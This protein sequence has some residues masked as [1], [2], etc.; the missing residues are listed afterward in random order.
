MALVP[1]LWVSASFA[2]TSDDLEAARAHLTEARDSAN[3]AVAAFSAAENK[4]AETEQHIAALEASID[5]LKAKAAQLQSIVRQR[6]VYAYTHKGQD[7]DIVVDAGNP[8]EAARRSQLL[9]QANERDNTAVRKLAA[10]NE[11][12][13]SQQDTLRAQESQQQA[14]KSQLEAK[15]ADL[16]GKLADAQ[17]AASALQAKLDAEIA[18]AKAAEDAAKSQALAAE[19]ASIAASQTVS[20]TGPGQVIGTPIGGFQCPVSGAA[21][22]DDFGGARGHPGIDMFVPTG[23]PAVAV[24]SGSVRY[25]ANEGDGGN[26]AYLS[27]S[28]G[29]TYFYAHFSSFVGGARDV[30]QGEIIGLTGMTGNASAP[31]LHFEIRLGGPNGSR[32]NPYPTLKGAGC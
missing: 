5:E 12:L 15:S 24:K 21:Y 8:V 6:A 28:D 19:R 9:D 25:V 31:H 22:S 4:L 20:D 16:Q 13:H 3:E 11:D 1:A 14:V 10:I 23:T 27:A 26:T 2:S 7:L 29:N 17:Q 18:A 32:A 30:S